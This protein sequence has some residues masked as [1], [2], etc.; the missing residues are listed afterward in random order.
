MVE[1]PQYIRHAVGYLGRWDALESN[2]VMDSILRRYY[3][4]KYFNK[5]TITRLIT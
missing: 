2:K 4:E 5:E 1:I 3:T